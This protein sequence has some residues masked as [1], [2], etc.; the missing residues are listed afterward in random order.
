MVAVLRA[1]NLRES[2]LSFYHVGPEDWIQDVKLGSYLS[3][4]CDKHHDLKQ[5]RGK[6]VGFILQLEVR[7]SGKSG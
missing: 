3:L 6:G 5:L 2:L 1:D 4:S 7:H